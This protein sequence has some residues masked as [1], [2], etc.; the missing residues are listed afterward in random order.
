MS[1][2]ESTLVISTRAVINTTSALFSFKGT[3]D[4]RKFF[5]LYE[6]VVTKSLT[7]IEKAEKIVA[8]P[9]RA[10]F[11]FYFHRFTLDKA[12]IEEAKGD[13]GEVLDSKDGL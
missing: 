10:D 13:I 2:S 7:G 3:R 6:N 11:G 8:Y 5:Y 4:A 9:T 1:K 12:P